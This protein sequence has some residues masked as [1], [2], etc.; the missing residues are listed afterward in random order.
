MAAS[1]NSYF[2]PGY[3]ISRTVIQ[4]E[5]RYYCGS[6]AIVRRYTHEGRDGFLVTTSGPPLTQAQIEDIKNASRDY[7]ERQAGRGRDG[8]GLFVNRP[9]P[10]GQQV[11]RSS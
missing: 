6:D 11:R 1:V 5:I 7:E 4:H 9:I 8:A 3:G 2:V 10:V